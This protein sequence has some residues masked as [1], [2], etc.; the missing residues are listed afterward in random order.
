MLHLF[1]LTHHRSAAQCLGKTEKHNLYRE[2]R[3]CLDIV[4]P[5]DGK[6]MEEMV[7]SRIHIIH[8]KGKKKSSKKYSIILVLSVYPGFVKAVHMSFCFDLFFRWKE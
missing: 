1:I 3:N 2:L 6:P 5:I 7:S 8:T 4:E